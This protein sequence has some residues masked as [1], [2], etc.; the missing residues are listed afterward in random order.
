MASINLAGAIGLGGKRESIIS[1]LPDAINKAG[2][3]LN[4]TIGDELKRQETERAAKREKELQMNEMFK[5]EVKSLINKDE[6]HPNDFNYLE[7]EKGKAFAKAFEIDADPTKSYMAK[8][9]E[10]NQIYSDLSEKV[11]YAKQSWAKAQKAIEMGG[12]PIYDKKMLDKMLFEGKYG[13][14]QEDVVMDNQTSPERKDYNM[15]PSVAAQENFG[16]LDELTAKKESEAT[17]TI[18]TPQYPNIEG[19]PFFDIPLD[20]R[21][22]E[23]PVPLEEFDKRIKLRQGDEKKAFEEFV[24]SPLGAFTVKQKVDGKDNFVFQQDQYDFQKKALEAALADPIGESLGVEMRILKANL[25]DNYTKKIMNENN[26]SRQK[27][28]AIAESFANE[29]IKDKFEKSVKAAQLDR[30]KDQDLTGFR[31]ADGDGSTKGKVVMQDVTG[32]ILGDKKATDNARRVQEITKIAD[33]REAKLKDTI[34]QLEAESKKSRKPISKESLD[35]VEK[36]KK[37]IKSM[38]DNANIIQNTKNIQEYV[39]F[40][41]Q[42]NADDKEVTLAD[43][44][45]QPLS[46]KPLIVY[47]DDKGKE[48]IAGIVKEYDKDLDI[49]KEVVKNVPLNSD[50]YGTMKVNKKGFESE[51]KKTNFAKKSVSSQKGNEKDYG[52]RNDGVTKKGSGYFGELKMKDGSGKVATELTISPKVNGKTM[53]IPSLVPTLTEAEKDWLLTNGMKGDDVWE[54]PIAKSIEKKAIAH[55]EKRI[56]EGKSVFAG[57]EKKV[58]TKKTEPSKGAYKSKSGITFE[59]K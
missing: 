56:K 54:Q 28:G 3:A 11:N 23:L 32:T 46:I 41:Q 17:K 26:F 33:E 27:A 24:G 13:T 47:R 35:N 45:N 19:K 59:V 15:S 52:T 48:R 51:Y 2:D 14:Q 44:N 39:A 12:N 40:S 9:A 22:K 4:K 7:E 1:G 29:V 57:S 16:T 31:S 38:R 55:A 18:T 50:N 34:A 5:K 20:Q 6:L 49:T 42:M 53:D 10:K 36:T 21:M 43:D 30:M 37:A 58:E 25:I 8:A